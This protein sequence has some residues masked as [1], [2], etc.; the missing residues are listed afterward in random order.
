[1]KT[2]KS[3]KTILLDEEKGD[4]EYEAQKAMLKAFSGTL[5][6]SLEAGGIFSRECGMVAIPS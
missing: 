4:P 2:N 3:Q 5:Y 1:M 6:H